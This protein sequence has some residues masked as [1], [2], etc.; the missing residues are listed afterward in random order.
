MQIDPISLPKTGKQKV[1]VFDIDET[2][3]HS[4]DEGDSKKMKGKIHLLIPDSMDVRK[5][6]PVCL[7]VRPHL[8]QCLYDLKSR[9]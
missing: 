2:M 1:L 5:M 6:V 3:V 4:I 9:F 8:M 7:N